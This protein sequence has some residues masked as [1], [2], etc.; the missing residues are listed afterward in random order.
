MSI[1]TI[2]GRCASY[3]ASASEPLAHSQIALAVSTKVRRKILR[4]P[5]LSSTIK[6]VIIFSSRFVSSLWHALSNARVIE[7][8][9]QA[10]ISFRANDIEDA[11]YCSVWFHMGGG[12]RGNFFISICVLRY[13][14][15]DLRYTV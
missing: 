13:N 12:V 11:T 8:L 2:S 6:S 7:T 9:G 3:A 15:A 10:Y 5:A 1:K 4:I 14:F